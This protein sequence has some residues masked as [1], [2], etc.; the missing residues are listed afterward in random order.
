M[1][2]RSTLVTVGTFLVT[3]IA[4]AVT[5][6]LLDWSLA[7]RAIQEADC[8]WLAGALGLFVINWGLRTHRFTIL[9]Q[10]KR[11]T[12][13]AVLGITTLH[14]MLTYMLPAK[15]GELSYLVLAKKHL[16]VELPESTATLIVARVFDF[17]VIASLL[18]LTMLLMDSKLPPWLTLSASLFCGTVF[19][20][21]AVLLLGVRFGR[22]RE[23]TGRHR[24]WHSPARQLLRTV[25]SLRRINGR[26]QYPLLGAV[27]FGIWFCI[28]AQYFCISASLGFEPELVHMLVIS[29]ILIPLTLIP[30]QGIANV[31]THEAAWVA[32]LSLF[33]YPFESA[34]TL[35][36][37]SHVVVFTMFVVLGLFG[38]VILR[39]SRAAQ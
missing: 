16:A 9:L 18:P 27:T 14:G 36:V 2:A 23:P 32:G 31:G 20:A 6:R 39:N 26:G 28:V 22:Q 38:Y 7:W 4:V 3:A 24:W 37:T 34:I 5:A 19:T 11:E 33:D 35:A 21:I 17:A 15:S 1:K 10:T 13:L 12:S 8:L 30:A 25:E 29:V